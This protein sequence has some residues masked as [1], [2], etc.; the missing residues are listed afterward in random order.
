M[1]MTIAAALFA[2]LNGFVK[3][4][5]DLGL[6][7]LQIA[8][9]R[10]I[11]AAG[12]IL[13]FLIGPIRRNGIGYLKPVRPWLMLFR[14]SS[15]SLGVILW[16][17]ALTLLPL[18]EV[19]AISFTAPLFATIGSALILRETVRLRRWTAIGVGF[20][21][22]LVILRP[23][24][25]P[26]EAG[27]LWAIGAAAGMAIAALTIKLLTR[28]EPADRIVFWS[29]IG[30]TVGTLIPALTVWAPM[31]PEI[32]L[33]GIGMGIAGAVSHIFLTNAFAVADA[34][35]VLPFDYARLPFVAVV[36]YVVF[37]QTSDMVTWIGAAIIAASA[38]Y[39]ARREQQV[40][41]H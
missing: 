23:G 3:Y 32:W 38:I 35:I 37:G 15:A 41:K 1:L 18:A 27:F 40:L 10:S 20:I 33:L 24:M 17:T 14:A 25:I 30:L 36:G 7:P 9:L 29:N 13:P 6:D 22:V 34:S 16:I 31:T 26:M 19:T 4:T 12:A 28:T 8:F 39:I 11:F 21:G 5:A 2:C